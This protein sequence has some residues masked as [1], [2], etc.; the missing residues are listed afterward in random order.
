VPVFANYPTVLFVI[1]TDSKW[2][3]LWDNSYLCDGFD[4]LCHGLTKNHGLTTVHWSS[5]DEDAVFQAGSLFTFRKRNGEE[6]IERSV[7]CSKNDDRWKFYASGEPLPEEETARYSARR[8]RDRLNE[9]GMLALLARL[10]ARPWDDDFYRAGEA[11]RIER[12]VI[13]DTISRK[14][15]PE[16]ACKR[17]E[18]ARSNAYL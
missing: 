12:T 7:C 8:I 11:F 3:V 6:I 15:F 5:S 14:T 4:S 10:G 9:E 16:F 13:P 2:S 1:P 17:M 18:V